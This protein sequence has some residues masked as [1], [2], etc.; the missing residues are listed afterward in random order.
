MRTA[1]YSGTNTPD[2][3]VAGS[4]LV[5]LLK[6]GWN[7]QP[8]FGKA[9]KAMEMGHMNEAHTRQHLLE[10][11]EWRG[12][13]SSFT[14][15]R[16]VST[17][18]MA[19]KDAHYVMA[20][21]DNIAIVDVSQAPRAFNLDG[22][23][24]LAALAL[25]L[26]EYKCVTT[27]VGQQLQRGV[28]ERYHN[29]PRDD[30]PKHSVVWLD[31]ASVADQ[32]LFRHV[33]LTLDDRMQLVQGA[34][35]S[36]IRM[37]LYVVSVPGGDVLRIVALVWPET[38]LAD[39]CTLEYNFLLRVAPWTVKEDPTPM[40]EEVKAA[41]GS[42]DL[43]YSRNA[44]AVWELLS[45]ASQTKLVTSSDNHAPNT[46]IARIHVAKAVMWNAWKSADDM[47]TGAHNRT[48]APQ[49]GLGLTLA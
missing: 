7:M 28:R 42:A 40:L 21:P 11:G 29:E 46:E 19:R 15:M 39:V 34:A 16:M 24:G 18:I 30:L 35:C 43:G 17:G 26:V 13:S 48:K 3:V 37:S 31:L 23:T 33:V 32:G 44:T 25:C 27:P 20:S 22:A 36:G 49:R 10:E 9:R 1:V 45:L 2:T 12:G 41:C 47:R 8:V 5:K 38:L 4:G 14:L 6:S